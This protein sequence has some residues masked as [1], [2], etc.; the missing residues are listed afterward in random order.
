MTILE[1]YM[2]FTQKLKMIYEDREAE[3]IS[4]WVFEKV[5]R[6]KRWE[7]SQNQ[8]RLLEE[9]QSNQIEN[10]LKEL[11]QHKPVQY[12]LNEAWFYKM[13]FYVDENVLLAKMGPKTV[14][15]AYRGNEL[16]DGM[17]Y[18]PGGT[19]RGSK[20]KDWYY[21]AGFTA[22]FRIFQK[23]YAPND[24]HGFRQGHAQYDCPKNVL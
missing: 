12:V 8:S 7:R 10:Y 23:E 21:F 13:K 18:P 14:E 3:N 15:L 11:L 19:P 4:D 5:T 1:A 17:P 22:S 9:N 16:K 2:S 20:P 24:T 6:L